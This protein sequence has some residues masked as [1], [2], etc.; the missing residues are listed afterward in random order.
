MISLERVEVLAVRQ[1]H[2]AK[3]NDQRK[4][5]RFL[6]TDYALIVVPL[7]HLVNFIEDDVRVIDAHRFVRNE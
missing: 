6:Q 3:W 1:A 2:R 7:T 5:E 4:I